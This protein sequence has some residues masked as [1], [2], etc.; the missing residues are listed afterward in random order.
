MMLNIGFLLAKL[1]D[2]FLGGTTTTSSTVE[3]IMT[4]LMRNP[5]VLRKAQDEVRRVM[6][7][8]P[9]TDVIRHINKMDYLKCIIKESLRLHVPAPLLPPRETTESIELQGYHIPANTRVLINAWAIQMDPSLWD[10]PEEFLPE[11]FENNSIDFQGDNFEFLPFGVGRR[12]CP[13]LKF[14]ISSVECMTA[15]L[16]YCFDWKLAEDIEA[17]DMSEVNALTVQKK[18]PL[19]LVPIPYHDP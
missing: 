16:L 6:G 1:Q 13:G 11:R 5:R 12:V 9:K 8:K 17:L 4:E 14:G 19:Y 2:M 18:V 10:S 3:W 15:S 7:N